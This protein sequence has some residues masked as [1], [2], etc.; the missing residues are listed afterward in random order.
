MTEANLGTYG[1]HFQIKVLFSLLTDKTF[2]NNISDVLSADYFESPAHKW[3]VDFTLKYYSQYHT[4]PTMEVLK[5]EMGKLKKAKNEILQIAVKA[6]LKQAYTT[7]ED[8]VEYVKEE[9]FNFCK[10]QML[11]EAL[12]KSVDLLEAGAFDDIRRVVDNALKAG[13]QKD[14]GLNLKKDIEARYREE[15]VTKVPFPWEAFNEVTD[16]GLPEGGLCII[17]GGTG[18]GKSTTAVH[19]AIKAASL[20]Y[21]V[22]YYT[23]ELA[24][25]YVGKKMD[26]ALTGIEMKSLKYNRKLIEEANAVLPGHIIIKE[27]Y[28]GRSSMDNIEAHQRHIEHDLG[29]VT[30]YI[31]IDYPEL[32]KPRTKRR[33][34]LEE[35]ND[36]YTDI[37][38]YLKET[39]KIGVAPSQ[40]NRA[41]MKEDIVEHDGVAGSIAKLFIAMFVFSISRKRKDKINKTAR[42]HVMKSRLGEDGMTYDVFMDLGINKIDILGEYE[43][44]AEDINIVDEDVKKRMR[45]KMDLLDA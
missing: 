42:F 20:G 12:L 9:F 15:D 13:Q 16:G 29:I 18:S 10:N 24:D 6:E 35:S 27:F 41:G 8:D 1:H 39:K 25:S 19:M 36:I 34:S 5:V 17:M 40:V 28:P 38:G 11:K 4:N 2:L 32:L 14:P 23:L 22:A 30:K 45:K 7:T 31:V 33:D 44:D 21:N 43:E 3:I 26:S 37:V